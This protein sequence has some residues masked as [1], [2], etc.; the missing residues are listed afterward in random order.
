MS[1]PG[2]VVFVG[3]GPGAADLLTLRAVRALAAA[4][5]VLH[6]ALVDREVLELCPQARLVAIGKRAG[7][8]STEQ[9]FI[10]RSLVAAARHH[11]RVVR[12]KGGDPAI[13]GRL[14]EELDALEAAGIACEIIPGVTAASAAAAAAGRSLTRRGIARSLLICTPRAGRGEVDDLRWTT[15]L[16]PSGSVAIYMAGER[17]AEVAT[18]LMR[19]GYPLATPVLVAR[20]V[21]LPGEQL[22]HAR[23]GDLLAGLE[24][25][26]TGPVVL[27]VGAALARDA[28]RRDEAL[29][30]GWAT[31]GATPPGESPAA[32][33]L[34]ASVA[35]LV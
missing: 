12:L 18:A 3:A 34:V 21:S 27:L 9:V 7:R 6:D 19:R 28:A 2:T 24:A 14:D 31:P 10:N 5:V 23:L 32:D 4:D 22:H 29:A 16:D 1:N 25:G 20:S 11:Q 33:E 15:G 26:G 30:A 35:R 8:A 13:F 17:A